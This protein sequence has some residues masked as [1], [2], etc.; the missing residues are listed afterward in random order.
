M[1]SIF[2]LSIACRLL[3][4]TEVS[5]SG[6]ISISDPSL[7]LLKRNN[8][9]CWALLGFPPTGYLN[10]RREQGHF[11]RSREPRHGAARIRNGGPTHRAC[12]PS[13]ASSGPIGPFIDFFLFLCARASEAPDHIS[14]VGQSGKATFMRIEPGLNK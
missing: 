8:S 4:R 2:P 14:Y 3:E 9:E 11:A 13:D 5:G 1:T 10:S 12:T 6:P 7:P